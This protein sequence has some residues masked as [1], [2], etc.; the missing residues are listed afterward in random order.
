MG[1]SSTAPA[2]PQSTNN[3]TVLIT[4]SP[5]KALAVIGEDARGISKQ[6]ASLKVTS[7]KSLEVSI[8]VTD[9]AQSVLDRIDGFREALVERVRA[10]GEGFHSMDPFFE[11]LKLGVTLQAWPAKTA[12]EKD[13]KRVKDERAR[14]LEQQENDRIAKQQK[15]DAEQR[16]KNEKVAAKATAAA[17]DAGADPGSVKEIKREVLRTA[18]PMVASRAVDTAR[19]SGVGL[20]YDYSAE[21]YDL[22]KFLTLCLNNEMMLNTL[23]KVREDM[24][25]AF[26][27][28]AVDQK[29]KFEYSGIRYK[30]TPRDV[31]RSKK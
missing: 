3:P 30:K 20:Q 21:I 5:E 10:A 13:L 1:K 4:Y 26:R 9:A 12:L 25:K 7:Q 23:S 14:Y 6:F 29:E 18:A 15:L 8:E 31:Q 27:S 2:A 28:M 16:E 22:T 24:E 17:K 19:D 11:G